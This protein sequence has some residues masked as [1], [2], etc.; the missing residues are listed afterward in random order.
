VAWL[1]GFL[2]ALGVP[3]T[4]LLDYGSASALSQIGH[5]LR[6]MLWV[7]AYGQKYPGY[8][9]LWQFTDQ[10]TIPGITGFVD[11]SN[12]HGTQEQYDRLFGHF[13]P[14]PPIPSP[15][16]EEETVPYYATNSAGTGFVIATDLSSKTGIVD[17]QDAATLLAT[18]KYEQ[19]KLSDAQITAIPDA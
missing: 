9:V 2:Q 16:P 1:N 11:E 10:A 14:P 13:D 18:G 8:G 3:R 4:R 6:A 17:G 12:W 7:A 5:Q 19:I 15:V